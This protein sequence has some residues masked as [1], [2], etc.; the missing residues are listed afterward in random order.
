MRFG[1]RT[2]QDTDGMSQRNEA[3]ISVGRWPTHRLFHSSEQYSEFPDRASRLSHLAL[4][5][6]EFVIHFPAAKLLF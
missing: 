3:R 5:L 6:L 4:E 2:K 1:N